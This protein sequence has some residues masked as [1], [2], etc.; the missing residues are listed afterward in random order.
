MTP[1]PVITGVVNPERLV[2]TASEPFFDWYAA[3]FPGV[4]PDEFIGSFLA[5]HDLSETAN[6]IGKTHG[7]ENAIRIVRG[8][9]VLASV[10][11]GGNADAPLN[12]W[13][14]GSKARNFS[15]WSRRFFPEHY[16]TRGDAAMDFNA[17]DSWVRLQDLFFDLKNDFP[18]VQTSVVGDLFGGKKG[19]T[20]YMGS[21]KSEARMRFYQKGLQQPEAGNP[22]HVR[23][24]YMV[25]PKGMLR[26]SFAKA[27]ASDLWTYS[28]V[29]RAA[30]QRLQGFDP[31]TA[32]RETPRRTDLEKRFSS[33]IRQYG[34]TIDDLVILLGS[35]EALG[36]A[37]ASRKL[38][39]DFKLEQG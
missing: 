25:K 15:E 31:G 35:P 10:L 26:W 16:L 39:Q 6:F 8:D 4:E 1:V 14:S 11:W 33:L 28:P 19:V 38:P 9:E 37:L 20:Y 29:S 32:V 7:Y 24:E 17:E 21:V 5:S 18:R 22:N 23:A 30:F 3:S 13:A 36:K 12:A 2:E 34:K 27:H